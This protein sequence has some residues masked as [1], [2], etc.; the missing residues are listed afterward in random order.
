[1][2][3]AFVTSLG[4]P[5]YSLSLSGQLRE[6]TGVVSVLELSLESL[7]AKAVLRWEWLGRT[8]WLV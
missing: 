6:L 7:S 4:S 5:G 8:P 3:S 1:M 2:I